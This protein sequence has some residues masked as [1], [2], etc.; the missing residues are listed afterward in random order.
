LR[1][2][3]CRAA[4]SLTVADCEGLNG[5]VLAAAPR[6][7]RRCANTSIHLAPHLKTSGCHQPPWQRQSGSSRN[8]SSNHAQTALDYVRD[9]EVLVVWKLDRLGRSLPHLIEAVTE[10]RGASSGSAR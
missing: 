9:G 7:P 4:K 10:L 8:P 1:L 6:Q 2:T 5:Q 3:P